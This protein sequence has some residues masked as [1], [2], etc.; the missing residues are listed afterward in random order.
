[1]KPG[2]PWN[3]KIVVGS[4]QVES[5]ITV[6]GIVFVIVNGYS[7]ESKFDFLRME[8]QLL[9]ERI[10]KS[11]ARQRKGRSGRTRPGEC[12]KMYTEKR[13]KGNG[14]RSDFGY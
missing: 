9:E 2:G 1:M 6:D 5:S 3:R 11:S 12:F 10:S 7:L 14:K 13:R 4:N 8:D